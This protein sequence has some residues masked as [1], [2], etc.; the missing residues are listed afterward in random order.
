[1]IN[2]EPNIPDMTPSGDIETNTPSGDIETNIPSGDQHISMVIP[3]PHTYIKSVNIRGAA[4]SEFLIHG[5]QFAKITSDDFTIDFEDLCRDLH[6]RDL[7]WSKS[8]ERECQH[9]IGAIDKSDGNG[10]EDIGVISTDPINKYAVS[11]A[12]VL[13]GVINRIPMGSDPSFPNKLPD[14]IGWH[15]MNFKRV[16]HVC[17]WG[18]AKMSPIITW[19]EQTNYEERSKGVVVD[20]PI[21]THPTPDFYVVAGP[22]ID[23][24]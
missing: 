13:M 16:D 6:E 11:T 22:K 17:L 14:E 5:I 15:S 2:M 8:I 10:F 9:A 18:R 23:T 4:G 21:H 12:Q 7:E 20:A 24:E 19:N 1:M 3:N